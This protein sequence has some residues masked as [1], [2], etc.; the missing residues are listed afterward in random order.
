MTKNIIS[1]PATPGVSMDF[2]LRKSFIGPSPVLVG[3]GRLGGTSRVDR[4]AEQHRSDPCRTI[5]TRETPFPERRNRGPRPLKTRGKDW[6]KTIYTIYPE[7]DAGQCPREE[8]TLPKACKKKAPASCSRAPLHCMWAPGHLLYELVLVVVFMAWLLLPQNLQSSH[9]DQPA[10]VPGVA[11]ARINESANAAGQAVRQGHGEDRTVAGRCDT[12]A[13][14]AWQ[15][16]ARIEAGKVG[17]DAPSQAGWSGSVPAAHCNATC[18][19]NGLAGAG[20][21]RRLLSICSRCRMLISAR[22]TR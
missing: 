15:S 9:K 5:A 7:K 21:T 16:P 1:E 20:P 3:L 2:G 19:P 8:P 10:V 6:T 14:I 11:I 13:P 18:L 4:V 17:H 22:V 12:L